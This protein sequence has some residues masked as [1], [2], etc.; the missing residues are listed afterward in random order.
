MSRKGCDFCGPNNPCNK[1]WCPFEET[2]S[3]VNNSETGLF[4]KEEDNE[5]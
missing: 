5:E 4:E 1:E 2:D 3:G